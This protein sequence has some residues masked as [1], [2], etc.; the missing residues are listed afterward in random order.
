MPELELFDHYKKMCERNIVLDFRGV[1]SQEMLVGMAELVRNKSY[2]EFGKANIVKR[3]F[4]V[5]IEMAQNIAF[6]SA[7][8]VPLD[9]RFEG[10]GAGIIMVTENDKDKGYTITSGNLVEQIAIPGVI[11]H[12]EKINRMD[13]ES[14]KQFYKKQIKSPRKKGKRGAGIGLIDIVRKTGNPIRYKVSP[15]DGRNSFIVLSVRIQE[16]KEKKNG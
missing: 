11:E 5:F 14:L 1:I 4:S 13:K 16:E 7:E 8:K 3:I 15:V 2:Q 10:V 9:D 12:C 6:Y